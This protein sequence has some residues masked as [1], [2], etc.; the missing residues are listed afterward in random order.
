M[1]SE[2]NG[3]P[4]DKNITFIEDDE[5]DIHE[6]SISGIKEKPISV[7]TLI[8]EYFPKFD[9]D[10]VIDKMMKSR[11][12][13]NSKYY[14]C[15]KQSIKDEWKNSGKIASKQGTVMHKKIEN[16]FNKMPDDGIETKEFLMFKSFW[17][18]FTLKYPNFKPYRSEWMVYD[19][20]VGVS[21]CID[22]LSGNEKD[23]LII[24]D[25][26]RSKEIKT[27]NK[28]EKGIGPFSKYDHCNYVHY[29]LQLNIYRHIL[30]TKYNKKI[31]Y[32]MLVILHP[33]QDNYK[34]Y[35]VPSIQLNEIWPTIKNV[36]KH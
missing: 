12:W 17:N 19:E 1:L 21:G 27:E 8:H 24:M 23:E 11:N 30:E 31:I 32:M 6:Y 20:D 2:I 33:E 36:I 5:H 26:K 13:T 14:S 29:C 34:C 22:F 18:D 28:Y 25:W 35:P 7:T 9:A 15:N 3:H 4:R 16:F 10:A